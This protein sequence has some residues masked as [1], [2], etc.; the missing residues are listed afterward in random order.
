MNSKNTE[1]QVKEFEVFYLNWDKKE[2]EPDEEYREMDDIRMCKK[3]PDSLEHY[4]EVMTVEAK[5]R[6]EVH[7]SLN[8]GPGDSYDDRLDKLKERSMSMGDIMKVD[9]EYHVVGMFGFD[10]VEISE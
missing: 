5:S 10:E 9:G 3:E 1:S 6:E 4:R 2:G 8:R 7:K